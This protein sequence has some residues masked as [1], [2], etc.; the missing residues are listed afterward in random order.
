MV[1]NE[2]KQVENFQISHIWFSVYLA[3]NMKG[4]LRNLYLVCIARF[5]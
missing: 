2:G 3:I 4:C 5:G 1:R